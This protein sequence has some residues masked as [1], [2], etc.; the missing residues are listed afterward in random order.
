MVLN[1]EKVADYAADLIGL[2]QQIRTTKQERQI[3]AQQAAMAMEQL[4]AQG[5]EA[6][7]VAPTD[8]QVANVV[9]LQSVS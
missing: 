4:Q 8:E 3:M 5:P 2:P 1:M 9:N 7:V 6:P